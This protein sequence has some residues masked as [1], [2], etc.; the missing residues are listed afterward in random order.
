MAA[1]K[2]QPAM[3]SLQDRDTMSSF[4]SMAV[5]SQGKLLGFE[6]VSEEIDDKCW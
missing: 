2:M 1:M 4:T 3:Y 6:I 5:S